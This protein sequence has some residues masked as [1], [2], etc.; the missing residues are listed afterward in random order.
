[1]NRGS[2]SIATSGAGPENKE[3][4]FQYCEKKI[5]VDYVFLLPFLNLLTTT[6]ILAYAV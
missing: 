3:A 2:G 5:N 1:M 6:V 4:E